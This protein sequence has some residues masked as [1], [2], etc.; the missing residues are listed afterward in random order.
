MSWAV[1]F[2]SSLEIMGK[3]SVP[4]VVESYRAL[5]QKSDYNNAYAIKEIFISK[6][7]LEVIYINESYKESVNS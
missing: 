4:D 1:Q 2:E 7:Y 3:I 5:I 6:N